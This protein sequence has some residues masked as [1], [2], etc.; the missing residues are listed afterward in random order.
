MSAP[1]TISGCDFVVFGGTGDLAMRKLLPSLYRRDH[2]GQL[3]ADFRVVA[4]SRAG[5][6][7]AGYRDKVEAELRQHLPAAELADTT[8]ER[9]LGRLHHISADADGGGDWHRL[10]DLLA[11]GADRVRVFYLAVAPRLYRSI[12]ATLAAY[13]LVG[14]STRVV[15]E[16][17]IGTDLASSQRVNDEVAA[18][19]REAQIYRID[20]YLGKETVQNLLVMRFANMLLEP[21]WNARTVDHVQITVAET[22][23]AGQRAGYYDGSGALRDMVQN[24]LLQLLCLVAMEPPTRIDDDGVRDEK[25]KVLQALAPLGPGDVVRAQYGAGLVDGVAVPSYQQEL[26]APSRTETYAALRAEVHNWRWRGVPFYLRTGKRL[27][28][29]ASEIVVVFKAVPHSIWPGLESE[30]TPNRLVI[31]L[32]PD[33]GVR[34]HLVAKEPG[35]GG[36]RFRPVSLDLAFAD[37]FEGRIPDAYERLL[38]DVVRGNPTLFMR[39]DEVEAAWRWTEPVLRRWE[40]AGDRP[41]PYAAGTTGPSAATTLIER[42]GRSWHEEMH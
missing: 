19:F 28:R 7:D 23:G 17:P 26:D 16:K 10:Q 3:P 34:M 4:V 24:H 36:F 27:D 14:D 15:L 21:L 12:S 18:V 25:L 32:Q 8:S 39:R 29:R 20:H 6:D 41:R 35:P 5:M 22:L 11:E 40:A 38:M 33:E 1:Q 30:L 42:D 37:Q 31:R 2:D 13:D 9:F